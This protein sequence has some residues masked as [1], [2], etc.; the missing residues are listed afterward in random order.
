MTTILNQQKG[1]LRLTERKAIVRVNEVTSKFGV[2]EKQAIEF[3][4]AGLKLRYVGWDVVLPLM[5]LV[6]SSFVDNKPS[7]SSHA[8]FSGVACIIKNVVEGTEDKRGSDAVL[9]F[10][11][12]ATGIAT[13]SEQK[14]Q[15]ILDAQA[16][17]VF[18]MEEFTENLSMRRLMRNDMHKLFESATELL[19][20]WLV[21]GNI[22]NAVRIAKDLLP[23]ISQRM[24]S[25]DILLAIAQYRSV[26][27][28]GIDGQLRLEQILRE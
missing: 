10:V 21:Q 5:D 19:G 28:V 8:V 22:S 27:R 11:K 7:G 23:D 24:V 17:I 25:G 6:K 16:N 18:G 9:R 1:K 20:A 12:M 14:T 3:D 4:V 15:G 2:E 13:R 26:V